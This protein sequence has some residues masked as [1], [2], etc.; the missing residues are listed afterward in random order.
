MWTLDVDKAI[1]QVKLNFFRTLFEQFD[2]TVI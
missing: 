2:L 1:A